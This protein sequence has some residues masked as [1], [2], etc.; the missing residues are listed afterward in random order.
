MEK[1]TLNNHSISSCI[2]CHYCIVL[3]NKQMKTSF[4]C[5]K[6]IWTE[7]L[8]NMSDLVGKTCDKYVKED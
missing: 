8:P 1:E 3:A 2:N 4:A 6:R 5:V 7:I